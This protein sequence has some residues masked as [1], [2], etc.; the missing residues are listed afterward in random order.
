MHA[1]LIP[2]RTDVTGGVFFNDAILKKLYSW[3][4]QPQKEE[5]VKII[6]ERESV[7]GVDDYKKKYED[8]LEKFDELENEL[9]KLK[10]RSKKDYM[11]FAIKIKDL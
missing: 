3:G 10:E 9:K 4:M 8:L 11:V 5:G 7:G 2:N 6:I 1:S